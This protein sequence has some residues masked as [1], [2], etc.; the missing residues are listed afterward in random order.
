MSTLGISSEADVIAATIQFVVLAAI[1]VVAG[2]VLTHCADAIAELTGLGRLL[3]GTGRQSKSPPREQ[4]ESHLVP[5]HSLA[6]AA[7]SDYGQP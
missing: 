3:V 2:T 6:C 5:V 7:G 1:I 4:V